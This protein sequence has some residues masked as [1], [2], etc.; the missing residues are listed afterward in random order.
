M[1]TTTPI[2]TESEVEQIRND[3]D[4]QGWNVPQPQSVK[5][6]ATD[7]YD[8]S[9]MLVMTITFPRNEK[10]ENLP[11]KRINP[12]VRDLRKL[13]FFKDGEARPVAVEIR[14]LGEKFQRA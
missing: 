9:P 11:W 1:V 4:A 3:L 13:V 5:V 14:R 2:V 7:D 10:P 12:L 6:V 8:G